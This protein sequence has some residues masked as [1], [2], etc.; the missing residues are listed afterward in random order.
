MLRPLLNAVERL[1]VPHRRGSDFFLLRDSKLSRQPIQQRRGKDWAQRLI[2]RRSDARA[3][4]KSTNENSGLRVLQ[5]AVLQ[6]VSSQL[7]GEDANYRAV[8][9]CWVDD[10]AFAEAGDCPCAIGAGEVGPVIPF[11]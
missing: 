4:L 2:A 11:G 5:V 6:A 8:R 10:P 7:S 3:F 9:S 1:L